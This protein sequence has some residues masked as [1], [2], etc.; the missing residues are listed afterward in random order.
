MIFSS[1]FA[2]GESNAMGLY[3]VPRIVSLT[4]LFIGI[5]LAIF[6]VCG[7]VFVLSEILNIVVRYDSA[8][9]PRCLMFMLSDPVELLFLACLC[10]IASEVCSIEICMGV[11][12]SLLVNLSIILYLLCVV[13][14]M[15]FVN[16]LLK[17]SAACLSVIAVF[18]SKVT[19]MFGVCG[20]FFVLSH[21]LFPKVCVRFVVPIVCNMLF[22]ECLFVVL[23]FFV[24]VCVLLS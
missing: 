1:D 19:E 4:D 6:H 24:Y 15:W 16:C 9:Y 14:L 12:F 17:C 10:L 22:P 5:I 20:V 13:S 7:I 23:H 8:V 2:I 11:D 18:L 3:D 21:L